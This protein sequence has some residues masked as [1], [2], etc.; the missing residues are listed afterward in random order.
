MSVTQLIS[1]AISRTLGT[2]SN[3]FDTFIKEVQN[4]LDSPS[5]TLQDLRRQAS[6]TFKGEIWEE[7]CVLYLSKMKGF[8]HAWRL[9]DVPENIR[10]SLKLGSKDIGIDIVAQKGGLFYAVQCKYRGSKDY[11]LRTRGYKS[12]TSISW[13]DLSTFYALC[14]RTGPW[15]KHIVMT[16]ADHISRMGTKDEKD[17]SICKKSF[18]NITSDEWRNMMGI[19]G[20]TLNS[21]SIQDTSTPVGQEEMREARLKFL[22]RF[23]K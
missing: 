19:T 16:N 11:N 10:E 18:Q 2:S 6:T 8:E 3:V 20:H 9:K 21:S 15:A 22:E 14:S 12:T 17:W 23:N 4:Y 1:K 13:K 7:F 5:H